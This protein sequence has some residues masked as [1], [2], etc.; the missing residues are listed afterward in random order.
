[1]MTYTQ[2][3]VTLFISS[4]LTFS[5]IHSSENNAH[6]K[7]KHPFFD[8]AQLHLA[9]LP[10]PA[11][12][13]NEKVDTEESVIFKRLQALENP[14]YTIPS[15][16]K[17]DQIALAY[18]LLAPHVP[19][20][21]EDCSEALD[22]S[23]FQS[24]SD[25]K[26]TPFPIFNRT[27]LPEGEVYLAHIL[28]H[29]A[30]NQQEWMNRQNILNAL[31]ANQD[32]CNALTDIFRNLQLHHEALY[33]L[34]ALDQE[35]H[36]SLMATQYFQAFG[37]RWLNTSK[38]F[39]YSANFVK[40]FGKS[41]GVA[42][43]LVTTAGATVGF[44]ARPGIFSL[45]GAS[46][47]SGTNLLMASYGAD[48]IKADLEVLSHLHTKVHA[49]RE[50][51]LAVE[52]IERKINENPALYELNHA[53]TFTTFARH[54]ESLSLKMQKLI[55]LAKTRTFT[56]KN[57]FFTLHGRIKVAYALLEEVKEELTPLFAALG[58]LDAY[59]SYAK[60]Y[61]ELGEFDILNEGFSGITEYLKGEILRVACD[62]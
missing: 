45:A 6:N 41:T 51:I 40:I 14:N 37:W 53:T 38:T 17:Y 42:S 23:L 58:E 60:V 12:R 20:T 22:L 26:N 30:K 62:F 24:T 61:K 16:S 55:S 35:M 28:T 34:W 31:T 39:Q 19:C 32:F 3:T 18:T 4:L 56:E 46:I 57:T 52:L 9:S 36:R 11:T 44:L 59:L 8:I 49:V 13:A 7:S 43:A 15:F 5:L 10:F 54:K 25:Y 33:S 29:P 21:Q 48:F 47:V 27:Y 50:L 1:M 2:K